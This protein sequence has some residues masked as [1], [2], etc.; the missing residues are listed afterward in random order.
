[1]VPIIEKNLLNLEL[2]IEKNRSKKW[3]WFTS[4]SIT[5]FLLATIILPA[6]HILD[7]SMYDRSNLD[8]LIDDHVGGLNIKDVLT[9]EILIIAFDYL[10]Q[11]P[12]LFSKYFA[13]LN[14]AV[15]DIDLSTAV[16]AS[17]SAILLFEPYVV[18]NSYGQ[19]EVLIDGSFSAQ[20]PSLYAFQLAKGF[21]DKKHIRVLSIGT[22]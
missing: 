3:V 2:N 19:A 11:Q 4:M 20:N 14:E 21:L 17:S 6:S 15:Y 5:G 16:K 13:K 8:K 10:Y 9:D 1:M 12:R 7:C 22:G 18:T